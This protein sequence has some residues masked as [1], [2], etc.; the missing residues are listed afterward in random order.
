MEQS[1]CGTALEPEQGQSLVRHE[2]DELEQM[3]SRAQNCAGRRE[4]T[5]SGLWAEFLV[6]YSFYSELPSDQGLDG[7]RVDSVVLGCWEEEAQCLSFS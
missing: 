7:N 2:T 6:L 1:S 5:L 4:S 3:F